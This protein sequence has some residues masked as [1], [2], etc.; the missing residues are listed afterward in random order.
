MAEGRG[1]RDAYAVGEQYERGLDADARALGA[2][3]TPPDVAESLVG[4]ALSR[5]HGAGRPVVCDPACG[6][7]VFLVAAAE[8][9]RLGGADVATVVDRLIV[10]VDVDPGAVAASS[11]ALSAWAGGHG[12]ARCVPRVLHADAL[13]PGLAEGLGPIDVVV[14]NPP[15]QS[16]LG[17]RTARSAAARSA[18]AAR[19]GAAASGYVD[20]AGLF[21]LV[22]L[23]L[24]A[25]GGV[26][27]LIMPRSFLVARDAEPVRRHVLATARLR[28]VWVPGLALFAA[29]VDV[30]ATVVQR[31]DDASSSPDPTTV[32]G[33]RAAAA[34][35][36]EVDARELADLA[37]W[38]P[39]WATAHAYPSVQASSRAGVIGDLATATAGFRDQYYGLLPHLRAAAPNRGARLA[40][41]AMLDPGACRWRDR[42]V[43]I[44]R[45]PWTAPWVDLTSLAAES[46]RLSNWVD[47]LLVPKVLVATQT[48][49][50]EAAAD[51]EGDLV[52]F[53]P[54][55]AVVPNGEVGVAHLEAALL[56]PAA[57]AW[58]F[59][60]FGGGAMSATA[61]K[62]AARQILELP[63][64]V[65]RDAWDD[66]VRLL[67]RARSDAANSG[68]SPAIEWAAF[69]RL[70]EASWGRTGDD[71]L[72]W[73]LPRVESSIH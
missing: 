28:D 61:L 64:P 40:T 59:R 63:V 54:V 52:P 16:Q 44:A 42:P 2:H 48:R 45:A 46:V 24:V 51:P 9:L 14:G 43:T 12:V 53:T 35:H 38:S 27:A 55:V 17:E 60:R 41:T 72:E 66:A 5:W 10:G 32:L 65:D 23:E 13:A 71:V 56:A 15:F 6:G 57:T 33:G 8:R 19:F 30:C 31:C 34:W 50:I 73:W 11:A 20:T 25:D 29:R 69:G 58:A 39:I 7:G 22:G 67:A 3:F 62:L 47:R 26:V 70:M 4:L 68:A 18:L 21:Q 37:T 36:G 1:V 49:V